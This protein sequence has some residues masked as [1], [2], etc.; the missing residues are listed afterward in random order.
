MPEGVEPRKEW[1]AALDSLRWLRDQLDG[2]SRASQQLLVLGD[3]GF[4]VAKFF[5]DLPE[6]V[7]LMARCARNRALYELPRNEE[8][9]RGR[10]RK[11]GERSRKP[12]DWLTERL[13]WR[14]AEF[15]VRGRK[16]RPRYRVEGPFVLEGAPDRPVF[17]VV[18]KG[19]NRQ[20]T[21]RHRKRREPSF[22][23][24]SAVWKDGRWV[25]PFPAA[26]LLG[27]MWQRWEVEVAH[28]ENPA[29][30]LARRSAGAMRQRS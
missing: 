20:A 6:S 25:L 14:R 4:C 15:M 16:I 8:C 18:V 11:Y 22:F 26:D 2:A 23:L 12:Q 27:W 7:D 21:G 28:R 3:G 9:R 29:S 1:E 5:H 24:V 17:L 13:G 30:G 19:V 10:K